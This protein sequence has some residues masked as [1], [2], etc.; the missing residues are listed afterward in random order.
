MRLAVEVIIEFEV[1]GN[2]YDPDEIC[3]QLEMTVRD[4]CPSVVNLYSD[5]A[6]MEEMV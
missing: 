4:T 6:R 1:E 5:V 2:E 3:A